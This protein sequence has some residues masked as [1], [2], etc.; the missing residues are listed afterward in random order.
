MEWAAKKYALGGLSLVAAL[1]VTTVILL[2][3]EN[4][5]ASVVAAEAT[6]INCFDTELNTVL[7]S[8]Q[9][10]CSATSIDLGRGKLSA[11]LDSASVSEEVH[12]LLM[13]RFEAARI[14]AEVDGVHL[15]ITSGFRSR[16]RQAELFAREVAIRGSESEAAKWVLPADYSHHPLGLALDINYPGDRP[17]A[18]WLENNGWRFGLCRVYQNE[19]WHFEG[20]NEPGRACP[21]LAPNALVDLP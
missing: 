1:A 12:P 8:S 13:N 4:E 6:I 9:E 21:A 3:H 18:A 17:G 16:E 20:A 14:S 5:S 11:L 10:S 19:W 15:Y 2:Q 7:T